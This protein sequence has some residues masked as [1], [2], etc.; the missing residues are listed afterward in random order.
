MSVERNYVEVPL[1]LPKL[2]RVS[3]KI[4]DL[5]GRKTRNPFDAYLVL[6]WLCF[7]LEADYGFQLE[8]KE[9]NKLKRLAALKPRDYEG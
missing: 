7:C 1:D 3:L 6:R 4:V 5:V 2:G 9:E 8:P